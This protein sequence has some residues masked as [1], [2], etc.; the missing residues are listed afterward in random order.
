[1]SSD[2]LVAKTLFNALFSATVSVM[3]LD[4]LAF[5]LFSR[6][7]VNIQFQTWGI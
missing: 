6:P 5:M 2:A 7:Q 3:I 1:M 4:S